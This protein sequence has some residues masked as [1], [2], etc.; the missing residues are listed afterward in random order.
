MDL[1]L[2][3]NADELRRKVASFSEHCSPTDGNLFINHEFSAH[4][5]DKKQVSLFQT[6]DTLF[7]LRKRIGCSRCYFL[8]KDIASLPRDFSALFERTKE[9]II[10]SVLDQNNINKCLKDLLLLSGFDFYD[11]MLRIVKIN[12]NLKTPRIHVK[13][14]QLDD[15]EQIIGI[16]R[17][18]FDPLI[19]QIPD[20]DEIKKAINEQRILVEYEPQRHRVAGISSFERQGATLYSRYLVTAEEYRTVASYVTVLWRNLLLLHSDAKRYVGWVR[21]DNSRAVELNRI[22]GLEPDG[23]TDEFFIRR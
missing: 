16:I 3:E 21:E 11:R 9:T 23:A 6:E 8:S 10:T 14:A 17:K 19:D 1:Y 22:F 20:E 7:L 15:F 2:V 5:L 12:Q 13:Y 18:N 4:W